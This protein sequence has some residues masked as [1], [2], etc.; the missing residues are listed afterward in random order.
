MSQKKL[1]SKIMKNLVCFLKNYH[2]SNKH[3]DPVHPESDCHHNMMSPA[4]PRQIALLSLPRKEITS[5]ILIVIEDSHRSV[6]FCQCPLAYLLS[7]AGSTSPAI[8]FQHRLTYPS[9]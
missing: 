3:L 1:L 2:K 4:V 9:M 6:Y 7:L 5:K 8:L